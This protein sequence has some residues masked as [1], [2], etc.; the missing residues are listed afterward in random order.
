VQSFV[1]ASILG[2]G[3]GGPELD[4]CFTKNRVTEIVPK[5]YGFPRELNLVRTL[6]LGVCLIVIL[7]QGKE[8]R[9]LKT[10]NG[11]KTGFSGWMED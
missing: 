7:L 2:F 1:K 8:M 4:A 10:M 5:T 3:C 6:L 9:T 11:R